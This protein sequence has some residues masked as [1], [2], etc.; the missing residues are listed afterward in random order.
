MHVNDEETVFYPP[1]F[2]CRNCCDQKGQERVT[3]PFEHETGCLLGPF[4]I[5]VL[6]KILKLNKVQ[7]DFRPFFCLGVAA[8]W[9]EAGE[10][11][12][13]ADSSSSLIS[14]SCF[15]IS[16]F[17]STLFAKYSLREDA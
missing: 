2:Y 4:S 17:S 12:T 1:S 14:F 6:Q 10:V 3:K 13:F 9:Y 16:F 5:S 7:P 8:E 15:S 11:V